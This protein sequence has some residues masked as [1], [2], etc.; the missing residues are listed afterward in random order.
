MTKNG[1]FLTRLDY[2]LVVRWFRLRGI[3][4]DDSLRPGGTAIV[5]GYGPAYF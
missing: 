1:V 2:L 4:L 3:C 5:L